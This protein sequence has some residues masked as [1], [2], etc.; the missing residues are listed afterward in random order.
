MDRSWIKA[1][2][3][4]EE[5]INGV[6]EFMNFVRETYCRGCSNSPCRKCLNRKHEPQGK[7]E[8]HILIYGM[9]STYDRW[10]HH[11]EPLNVEAD[12]DAQHVDGA[13]DIVVDVAEK[14]VR[15]EEE[16]LYEDDRIHDMIQDLYGSEDTGRQQ[17]KFAKVIEEAK[18]SLYEGSETS[19]FSFVVKLLHIKSFCRISNVAFNA[20][21]ALL[22]KSFP[23]C[24]I[25]KSYDEALKFIRA[26]GLGY[27]SIH[28]CPNNYVLFRKQ[29]ANHDECP[30]CGAS[31]WKDSDGKK[32][33]PMKVLRHF[34]LIPRLQRMYCSKKSSEE[35]QWHKLKKKPVENEI[36]HPVDGEAW[37]DF[38]KKHRDFAEDARNQR[39]GIGTDGFN[40]FGKMSA[41]YSMWPVFVMPYN[42]PPWACMDQC[43]LMIALLIPGR[44]SPGK[45]FDL[46]LEP[47][48]EE[49]LELWKGVSTYDALS[50][51]KFNL[52]AVVLWC[53]HDYPGLST[54]SGRVTSGYYACLHCDKDP[55]SQGIRNKICYIGLEELEFLITL[56][57]YAHPR[58]GWKENEQ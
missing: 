17:S 58:A 41:S 13:I 24:S 53:I 37:K 15:L 21:L 4:S 35:V 16:D 33:I 28:V 1:R 47:L 18:C 43:N 42:L 25:P 3:F 49:L 46:F 56:G 36:S 10:I 31:R 44:N 26:L 11:G 55:C 54:L 19:R 50:E 39:I 34:P 23:K 12:G 2:K 51:K 6:K 20:I 45:D 40:P 5:Y 9:S 48:V 38:D 57:S 29:Y 32:Q 27:D 22:A 52:R 8:D 14:D 30:V 7:V